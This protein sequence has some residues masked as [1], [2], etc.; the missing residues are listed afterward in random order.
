MRFFRRFQPDG[1][2]RDRA[3]K[4]LAHIKTM[5]SEKT[6]VV[7]FRDLEDG[8][9]AFGGTQENPE[10]ILTLSFMKT[11]GAI[12]LY[13]DLDDEVS[14]QEWDFENQRRFEE[15]VADHLVPLMAGAVAENRDSPVIH[16]QK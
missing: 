16:M 15:S 6:G 13:A 4:C 1:F 2:Q 10:R 3:D 12:Y 5:V 11:G 8:S 9:V 14:W 7:E